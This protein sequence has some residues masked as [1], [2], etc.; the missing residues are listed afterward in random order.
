MS[1]ND[2]MGKFSGAVTVCDSN[3]TILE[4]NEEATRVFA[5]DGGAALVGKNIFDCHHES[6]RAKIRT[7]AATLVP[8]VY[9][10]QK[11]G[12]KKLVYQAPWFR[13]DGAFA[14]LVEWIVTLPATVPHFDRDKPGP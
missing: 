8:N 1:K 7:I 5:S 2:W 9:T 14:G 12:K 10:I 3:G 11:S 13:A 4:M 6:A